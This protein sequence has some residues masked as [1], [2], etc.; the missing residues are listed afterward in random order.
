MACLA[1]TQEQEALK[2]KHQ[3]LDIVNN[4]HATYRKEYLCYH[5][6]ERACAAK[7][8]KLTEKT[9]KLSRKAVNILS[10]VVQKLSRNETVL[11]NSSYLEKITGC[12]PRQN[13][14]ILNELKSV[15]DIKY[16]KFIRVNNRIFKEY[17]LFG[18]KASTPFKTKPTKQ[19]ANGNLLPAHIHI[20]NN[21]NI[22]YIDLES[23]F[24]ENSE[25]KEE[26]EITTNI[27]VKIK[28]YLPNKRKK[29]TNAEK[30]AKVFLFNQYKVPQDLASHYPL[31]NKDCSK[32]QSN[33]GR[34]FCLIA[35]NEILLDMSKRL[36]RTFS[37]KAQF[38]SYFSKCLSNE[39]RD[40]VKT[41][42]INFRIKANITNEE[43]KYAKQEAILTRSE[44]KAYDLDNRVTDGFQK[45]PV[46]GLLE[47]IT[48]LSGE[49]TTKIANNN[50]ESKVL[51]NANWLCLKRNLHRSFLEQ[52]EEKYADFI[53]K[54]WFERLTVSS[55]S[56]NK[57]LVLIGDSFVIDRIYQEYLFFLEQAILASDF[58]VEIHVKSNA[59]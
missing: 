56:D 41:D 58:A 36:D 9:K 43:K 20:E 54:N 47:K 53:I 25:N 33:S 15:L 45:L 26:K 5:D 11:F 17:Y 57:R 18:F 14:N 48:S 2:Q 19:I 13:R 35:M 52:Y 38:I 24:L 40:A 55:D 32:I 50:F 10:I 7:N 37:S 30:K 6:I 16:R 49:N 31:N 39:K 29:S 23:N 44:C 28:K 21:K 59:N 46:F 3:I 34:M 4:S 22:E 42:N 1:Q 51:E 12:K 27:L 8:K